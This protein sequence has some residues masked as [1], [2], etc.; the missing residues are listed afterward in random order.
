[1]NWEEV[2]VRVGQEASKRIDLALYRTGLTPR[3][4]LLRPQPAGTG[5]FF[6]GDADKSKDK[7]AHRAALLRTHL[8]SEADA[9]IREADSICRHQFRL[10]GYESIEYCQNVDWH[11]DPVHGKRSPL[12]PW[13]KIDFLD[14]KEVGDH[15]IIWELN[16]H[17]HL[18]ALA[19]A[20][21]LS[22]NRVYINELA[23]QWQSWQKTN[24]Y[25]LGINW[26]SALEVAFR[27][28][29]WLWL[30]SLLTGC[31]EL[32]AT[33]HADLLLALQLHGRYIEQYLST[34][35]SPNTHLLGEAVALFF[36]GTLCPEIPSAQRW[37]KNGWRIVLEESKRQVRP[38][39][40]YFEQALYYHVYAL[41]F[42]LHARTLAHKNEIAVPEEFDN[43]TK[44]MLDVIQALSEVGPLESFGDDDG[45][46]A[47]NPRRNHVE[48]MSDPLALGAILYGRDNYSAATLTEEA[49]WLFGDKA[50]EVLGEPQHKLAAPSKAFT[51]GGLYLIND[52]EPCPQQ[53]MI[54]AGPQGTARSGHGHA[55]ALSIRLSLNGRRFLVDPG[56]CC[57]ISDNK[58]RDSFRDTSAH[59]TLVV[60]GLDQA[61]PEGPFAWSSIP[62]VKVETWLNG[63]TF[64]FFSG[65]HDGYR[66]LPDPVMH[67]RSV[68]HV[69]GGL[70]FL[71]DRAEG[72]RS[73]LL[74]TFWHFAPD[75][76]V[77]EERG[78]LIA[79]SLVANGNLEFS[80]LALV[81]DGKSAWKTEITEGYISPAYGSKQIAPV[82]RASINATLPE[83][84]GVLILPITRSSDIG[85]FAAID[86]HPVRGVRGYRYQTLH[87]AEFIFLAEENTTW[88][89][90]PW[91]SDARLLYCKLEG[92]RFV[93]VIMISG[94]FAEYRGKR[95]VS[96]ASVT[97]TFEWADGAEL[98]IS[99]ASEGNPLETS[100]VTNLEFLDSAP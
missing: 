23:T 1:M 60:D 4:P 43:V 80:G 97:E 79:E 39:G 64:D 28:L 77:R 12:K 59:N 29:S 76:H 46:R 38:D 56:T 51:S 9:I 18:V 72:E 66:R 26:A 14:F 85:T 58:D 10:L 13:F 98:K 84:C 54:D 2:R 92:G 62:N 33:F 24:P 69:R 8:P 86:E 63:K 50:I 83:E 7:P 91:A 6:F 17:Q 21:L 40:V 16:R 15:K 44:K 65:S 94:S 89:C 19:K 57:Y 71:R 31:E 90:G 37:Q 74:E 55:D 95:F 34:Y 93:H 96:Q 88:T 49:I 45:G 70:W 100:L 82:A 52:R 3:G 25:P 99:S 32:P 81:V 87:G 73:H 27:S 78:T 42:F 11:A 61:V 47:F 53:L 30:R 5:K 22:G 48:H 36:I 75:L 68:F 35:Y 20:W 41:D 67:R